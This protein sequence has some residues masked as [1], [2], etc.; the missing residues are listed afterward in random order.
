MDVRTF[1]LNA[2]DGFELH[3]TLYDANS[4]R[5]LI[6]AAAM[7]VKRRYYDAF[8]RH[9]AE[10]G[11]SVV[12][13]DYRGM[14]E[15]RPATLRG[16][17]A[18]ME[19][20]GRYDIPAVIDWIGRELRPRSLA[21][22]GHSAGGQL[23]GLAPNAGAVDR[24]LFVCSQSG[25]WRHW[26]GIRALGL[27]T[28]WVTMPIVSRIAGFFPSRLF[29]LGS[30]DLPRGI[31]SQWARWG[32]HPEYLFR[33]VDSAPYARLTAPILAYSF[34]DDHYAPRRAV[35]ALLAKYSAA[36]V[37]HLHIEERGLGHFDFFR[38]AKGGALWDDASQWLSG[39][40]LS[41]A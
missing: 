28:L 40:S 14:G 1:T 34:R 18:T 33:D 39:V 13:F 10:G 9:V 19:E 6:M 15:S 29:G 27:G 3:A 35:D 31:A 21:Y 41:R 11:R 25:Y 32:R 7:G 2:L 20:W 8:A 16:F 38:K 36:P 22:A 17:P 5:S 23:A 26:P 12:T 30:E 37:T 4:D 24:F